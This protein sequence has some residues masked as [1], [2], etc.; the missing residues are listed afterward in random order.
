MTIDSRLTGPPARAVALE[1]TLLAHGVPSSTAIQLHH[2]LCQ[3]RPHEGAAPALLAMLDGT[4]TVGITQSEL[5]R[6]IKRG[7]S[8]PKVNTANLG[9]MHHWGAD[10]ATTVSTTMEIASAVGIRLFA[11]GGLGGVHRGYGCHLDV[12]ADLTAFTR[13]PVAVVTAGVKS[14]LDIAA[15]REALETLGITVVGYQTDHFPAFYRRRDDGHD[16]SVDA[17]FDSINELCLFLDAEMRRT[18]RGVVVANPISE[19][20]ELD[21]DELQTWIDQAEDEAE[22][23]GVIGRALTPFILGR[24][25]E[26]SKGKTIEANV[27]LVKNNASVAGALAASMPIGP[28]FGTLMK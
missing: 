2:S 23:A 4:P 8:L 27:A 15:T 25:H 11:T 9:V 20:D 10:A 6:L 1:S 13:F 14:I 28:E 19:S 7:S 5:E 3:P 24:I 22:S 21:G 17:R 26:F 12:S 18:G 16:L